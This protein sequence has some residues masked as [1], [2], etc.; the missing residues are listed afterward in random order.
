LGPTCNCIESI[1]WSFY[2]GSLWARY[3]ITPKIGFLGIKE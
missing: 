1:F 2:A 3:D